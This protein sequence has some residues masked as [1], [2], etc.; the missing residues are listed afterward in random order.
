[1]QGAKIGNVRQGK[2]VTL[3]T[4]ARRTGLCQNLA[5]LRALSAEGVQRG[6]MNL[7]T[8]NLAIQASVN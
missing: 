4:L 5:A 1:M 8:K 6:H 2:S 3:Q 7:H